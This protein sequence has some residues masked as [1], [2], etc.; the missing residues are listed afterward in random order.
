[1][2]PHI[3]SHTVSSFLHRIQCLC[4]ERD[5]RECLATTDPFSLGASTVHLILYM[6]SPN[7]LD[8]LE[9]RIRWS[10]MM[11]LVAGKKMA[12]WSE[13]EKE[14]G[15]LPAAE[16]TPYAWAHRFLPD[17]AAKLSSGGDALG[18][19][20]PLPWLNLVAKHNQI[21]TWDRAIGMVRSKDNRRVV[22]KGADWT[23][24]VAKPA[25]TKGTQW[26]EVRITGG[27]AF[28]IGWASPDL[29]GKENHHDK[30]CSC[31]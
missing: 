16:V 29:H 12:G 5:N 26:F 14:T 15:L 13:V 8:D 2:W 22:N 31:W 18:K 19:V 1:M 20:S 4:Q 27:T 25:A 17:E 7:G 10:Q 6:A 3:S 9:G 23:C 24:V 30:R 11:L 28:M 21:F